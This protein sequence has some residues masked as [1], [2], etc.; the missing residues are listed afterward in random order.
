MFDARVK[1]PALAL[2]S[3]QD[4]VI[5]LATAY[6]STLNS[7]SK[8]VRFRLSGSN[9]VLVEGNDG[10]NTFSVDTGILLGAATYRFFTIE[11][12]RGDGRYYF[13]ISNDLVGALS[14]PAF[15]VTDLLQPMIGIRKASGTGVPAL[16]ID[17]MRV[18]WL[19][20]T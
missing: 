14:L 11:Q 19:R 16:T 5:G 15:A 13:F 3:V 9:E 20:L 18:R 6:N 12:K 8:Y 7:I 4:I 2:T 1:T 17:H 10:T